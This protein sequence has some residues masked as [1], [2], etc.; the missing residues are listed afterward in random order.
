MQGDPVS[1]W[2]AVL[3]F[4]ICH[5]NLESPTRTKSR[6]TGLDGLVPVPSWH[7]ISHSAEHLKAMGVGDIGATIVRP[8][9]ALSFSDS[10]GSAQVS[11][12]GWWRSS[13]HDRTEISTPIP[14]AARTDAMWLSGGGGRSNM[15]GQGKSKSKRKSKSFTHCHL[16]LPF[17][18]NHPYQ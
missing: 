16:H 2:L 11:R 3:L 18:S 6:H 5:L 10:P 15:A 17:C 7:G 8:S 14:H 4:R 13:G 12:T 9:V 1:G